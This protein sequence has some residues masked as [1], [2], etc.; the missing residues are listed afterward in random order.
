[1][2]EIM[3]CNNVVLGICLSGAGISLTVFFY[4]YQKSTYNEND[5]QNDIRKNHE[6]EIN[7]IIKEQKKAL[8]A[9]TKRA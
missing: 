3:F 4:K 8:K 6:S 9:A 7:G 5:I 1:M 2:N